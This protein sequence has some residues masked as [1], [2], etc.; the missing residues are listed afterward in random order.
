MSMS[1]SMTFES[2]LRCEV[3]CHPRI[4]GCGTVLHQLWLV[5]AGLALWSGTAPVRA[6]VT[7]EPWTPL[8][9]GIEHSTGNM[10]PG[11]GDSQRLVVHALRVDLRDPDIQLFTTPLLPNRAEKS[12]I[13]G[14][15]TV[16]DFLRANQLQVAV[17][18]DFYEPSEVS[19]PGTPVTVIGSQISEGRVV[20]APQSLEAAATFHFT[21]NKEVI[22]LP[23]NYPPV[24]TSGIY[25]SIS[26]HYPLVMEG[27]SVANNFRSP[28][29][30]DNPRTAI[31]VTE[32]GNHLLL[33]TIDG[34]Q[35]GYSDGCEDEET[36]AWMLRYGAYNA[37][38]VD[39]GG[40][41]TMVMA[42]CLGLPVRLN[43]PSYLQGRGRERYIGS[44]LGVYS[45]GSQGFINQVKVTPGRTTAVLRW[46]TL[47]NATTQLE[48][49][50]TAAYGTLT[51][52]DPVLTQTHEV[53]LTNLEPGSTTFFRILATADGQEYSAASCFETTNV[54]QRLFDFNQ[55]WK[56]QTNVL[57]EVPWMAT[58]YSD[59]DWLGEGPGLLYV[60][61]NLQVT[62]RRTRLPAMTSAGN[63]RVA[64]TFYFR[65]HFN[66]TNA[67]SPL[68]LVFSNYL[69]D[70][71]IFYLN[72][73]EIQRLRM[74]TDTSVPILWTTL[75][76]GSNPTDGTCNGDAQTNCPIVFKLT[77][78]AL[79][80]LVR[81]DNLLAVEVHN[82]TAR[83]PDVVFGTALF[84]ELGYEPGEEG[85]ALAIT[86]QPASSTVVV[87][88]AATI[89]ATVEGT[90]PITYSWFFNQTPLPAFT[91]P[92][93]TIDPVAFANGGDYQLIARNANGSVTS[94]VARLTVV[95]PPTLTI[96]QE[97][98]KIIV[99]WPG[100]GFTLQQ[101][102]ELRASPAIQW[103]TAPGAAS[104]SPYLTTNSDQSRYFRLLR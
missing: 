38:N 28:I 75:A 59:A 77:G 39:G 24:S 13:T 51:P 23:T 80:N 17:N 49:G 72:G 85:T 71:A 18:A 52:L 3:S 45:R 41:T 100:T 84:F 54:V 37:I 36:A 69:D 32:D 27:V 76:N 30:G 31:G 78:H 82:F 93:V 89:S 16:S 34:R 79:T 50:P 35:P 12:G 7:M 10:I 14:A 99:S 29:N 88:Q 94:S 9:K 8:F 92:S 58:T 4:L 6:T 55:R 42:D 104:T 66:F 60:E 83:S 19:F 44:H 67:A 15:Q 25:T 11:G 98:Q 95:A 20:A 86:Q 48:Y 53:R 96:R 101:A 61:D 87:G 33:I 63:S 74:P 21:T 97:D 64:T 47:S 40:S 1:K 56:Y 43:R 103:I 26:G 73:K 90:A 57:D 65:T 70:G 68:S 81:G 2:A 46:T 102:A 22:F 91:G 5:L 62:V